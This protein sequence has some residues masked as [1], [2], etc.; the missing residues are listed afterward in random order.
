MGEDNLFVCTDRDLDATLMLRLAGDI[1]EE[2][3]IVP[4]AFARHNRGVSA[5]AGTLGPSRQLGFHI[6]AKQ[7]S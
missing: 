1:Q 4:K 7:L 3:R 6:T 2:S 5:L